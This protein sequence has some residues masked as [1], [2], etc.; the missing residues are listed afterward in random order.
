M[1]K[2]KTFKEMK[3][4]IKNFQSEFKATWGVKPEVTVNL[5]MIFEKT[6]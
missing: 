1:T 2:D 5:D 4:Q 6:D 3:T